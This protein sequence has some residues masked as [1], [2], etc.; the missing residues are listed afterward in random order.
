MEKK[1]NE[2]LADMVVFYHKLQCYH[3]YVKGP[4]FFLVHAKLEECYD[5]IKM[6]LDE[7]AEAALMVGIA[8]EARL[9]EFVKS[10]SIKEPKNEYVTSKTIFKEILAD[11]QHLLESTEALKAEAEESENY[12]IS[13]KTDTLIECFNKKIW[14]LS[15]SQ[16]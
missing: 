9:S 5:E 4:D 13:V 7:V 2:M 8:P 3:W 1:I 15:Q 16:M 12:L 11:Y 10:A 6:Q 14:T